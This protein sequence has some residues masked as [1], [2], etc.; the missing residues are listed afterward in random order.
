MTTRPTTDTTFCTYEMNLYRRYFDMVASGRKTIEVR[1]HYPKLRSLTTGDH[2][3][4]I[5]DTD[6][7]LTR[8]KRVAR[9]TS[10]EQMLDAE[11]AARVNPDSPHEQQLVDM[12]RIYSPEKEALGVLAIEIE[13][14]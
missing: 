5:Y 4:F 3:R 10:F 14:A 11:D 1:V 2:I 9:Y 8:V 12:R 7:V 6:S 13:L